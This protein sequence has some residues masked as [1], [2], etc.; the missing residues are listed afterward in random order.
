METK[1]NFLWKK[2]TL[3]KYSVIHVFGIGVTVFE[4]KKQ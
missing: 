4:M 2:N 3:E 1:Y